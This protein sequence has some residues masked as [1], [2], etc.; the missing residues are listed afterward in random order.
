MKVRLKK[1]PNGSWIVE[2]KEWFN[3]S[4]VYVN[5]F[6]HYDLTKDIAKENALKFAN[7]L[8]NPEII[9]VSK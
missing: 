9:E 2:K 3:S 5:E 4:W 6:H 1:N 8:I 7:L